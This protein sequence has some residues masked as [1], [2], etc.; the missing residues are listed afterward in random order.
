M[1]IAEIIRDLGF[2]AVT[3][4]ACSVLCRLLGIPVMIAYLIAGVLA[5]PAMMGWVNDHN[6]HEMAELG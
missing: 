3:G 4:A 2:L 6:V 1:H 5:G